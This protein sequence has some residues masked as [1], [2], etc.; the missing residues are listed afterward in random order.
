MIRSCVMYRK[1]WIEEELE[2]EESVPLKVYEPFERFVSN[3]NERVNKF[4]K[5]LNVCF[6]DKY[7]AVIVYVYEDVEG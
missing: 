7:T 5:V 1:S 4:Q 3:V 2:P 6:P